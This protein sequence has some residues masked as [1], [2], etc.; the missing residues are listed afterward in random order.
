M[1]A[2]DAD[3]PRTKGPLVWLD[4]D[5]DALD[6]AHDHTR[7]APNREHVLG[8]YLLNSARAREALG[9]PLRLAYGPSDIERLDV[10]RA[11][12]TDA[13]VN[14]FVHGGAW[15]SQT[16]AGYAMLAE[17]FVGAGAH[18]VIL[19]FASVDDT[20][21]D[22]TPLL[23]QIRRAV[24]WVFEHARTFGGDP[25]G[26]YLSGH[27]SGAHLGGC[28]ITAD[29]R[30]HGLPVDVLKGAVLVSGMYDLRPVRLS[31]RSSYVRFTAEVEEDLSPIRHLDRLAAPL[32]LSYGTYETPEFQ[33]QTVDFHAAV[34][35]AGKPATLLVGEGYN[36]FEI[37]ETLAN[38]YG[39]LGRAALK[40]MGLRR[41]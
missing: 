32:I 18:C 9:E 34:Q 3:S 7:Y 25:H 36:H 24:A 35:A 41:R 30:G 37:L 1:T 20:G 12:Q 39:L 2:T 21:G 28:A 11:N 33:R 19:D 13:P 40:Q 38:P 10:Y 27:S 4:M 8:R 29:W 6:D 16:A 31:K 14:I 23:A 17:T 15:R 26:L 5:Q 22:L